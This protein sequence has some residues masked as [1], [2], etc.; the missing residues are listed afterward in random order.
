M[1][2]FVSHS[3]EN[4]PEFE[5]VTDWLERVNVPF[6][7]PSDVKSGDS[8]REQLRDAINACS[9]C[10]FVATHNSV[11][12]SWCGAELGAFWGAGLPIIVY[13]ADSS[14]PDAALP[15]IVQ[16]DVW[17]RKLSRVAE[18]AAEF[19]RASDS[20]AESSLP[21]RTRISNITVEQLE[22]LVA[23]AMALVSAR[24]NQE[25]SE[26][27]VVGKAD[28][29]HAAASRIIRGAE[30]TSRLG[31]SEDE[32][33]RR[34]VLWV[35]DRPTNNVNERGALESV[36]L[37][38]VLAES[39]QE[40]LDILSREHFAAIISDMGR[41]EGPREGYNLLEALRSTDRDTPFFIYAGS[42]AP[43]HQREAAARGAQ[44]TTNIAN[45]LIEMVTSAL[46]AQRDQPGPSA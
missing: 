32:S 26:S 36:G 27:P 40:A 46:E 5:N 33:W 28:I 4:R 10:I 42:H 25:Y 21:P 31:V 16:G 6:W 19:T 7:P 23:G 12:S 18:R 17:E 11:Q 39:T 41:R 37:E 24:E 43:E 2:V 45:E 1:V 13:L 8:L 38:F 14:L 35:D 44:G 3:F 30:I 15:P 20:S 29:A 22:K 34:R 9:V